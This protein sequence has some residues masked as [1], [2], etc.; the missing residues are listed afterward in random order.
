MSAKRYSQE[1]K[2]RYVEEFMN[3]N[4]RQTIFAKNR[5]IPESTFRGWLSS[6]DNNDIVFGS[7]SLNNDVDTVFSLKYQHINIELQKGFDKKVLKKI[8]GVIM[9]A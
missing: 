6:Q 8:M 2:E 1:E 3:S 5:G 9:N 4:E 7:I